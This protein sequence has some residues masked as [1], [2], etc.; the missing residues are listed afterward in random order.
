M[1]LFSYRATSREGEIR[2]GFIEAVDERSAAERLKSS[3]LIPLKI[4]SPEE[5]VKKKITLRRAR[6]DILTFTAELSALLN[7]GL[8]LD[9]SLTILNS[10]IENRVMKKTGQSLLK[11]IRGGSSFSDALRK[12]PKVF[13][14]L[15]VSMV[16]AGESGGVLDLVLATL[17]EFLETAK[18]L[19]DFVVTS[20][21]YPALLLVTSG[22]SIIL[23]LTYVLPKFSVIFEEL[24]ELL[25]LPTRILL[26]VSGLIKSFWWVGLLIIAAGAFLFRR[27][28]RTEEGRRRFDALKLKLMADIIVKLETARF[29]RTLGTL[30]RSGVPMME[31]LS[32]AREVI[33][34]R[35]ISAALENVPRGVKEGRGMA[36]PLTEALFFPPLALSLIRVGEETGQLDEMLL[37]IAA[38]YEKSL[39]TA[40]K[41]FMSLFEPAMILATGLVIGFIA[42][43]MFMAVF[44]IL[45][46]P[47]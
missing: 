31:A 25:P 23:L 8:P 38:T 40:V 16:K 24:G 18:E 42:V 32:G 45:E 44:S 20:L 7:A 9:R 1:A 3:G 21:I 35:V 34:N 4:T 11:S 5:Q 26:A 2:D 29:C 14:K 15:Y 43:A 41:R 27:Y 47:F 33:G 13:P 37:K 39:K 28:V 30:L 10:V 36:D 17:N 19:K 6:G 12:H 46:V 22:V